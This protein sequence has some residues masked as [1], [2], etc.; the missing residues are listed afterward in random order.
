MTDTVDQATDAT[1]QRLELLRR[2]LAER[3][4]AATAPAADSASPQM[5]DGQRRMWFVQALDPDGTVANICVSYRL[6]GPLDA[7]RL[8]TALA[9]VAARHP[10]LRTTYPV[11][12][13]GAPHPKLSDVTPAFGEHD[14]TDL[15]DQARALRLEVLAQREF[16]TPFRLDSDAPLR[17]TLIRVQPDGHILLLVA[18]HIAWVRSAKKTAH[19][20]SSQAM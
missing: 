9:A 4:L 15:A 19:E 17:L 13:T 10:V 1:D 14:L 6:T 12:D 3:G 7:A 8:R 16:G 20:A 18:H 11:D 5:S 2:R